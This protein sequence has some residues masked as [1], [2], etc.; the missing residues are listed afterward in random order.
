MCYTDTT[1]FPFLQ[2]YNSALAQE[3]QYCTAVH[4]TV[5]NLNYGL[6]WHRTA[7]LQKFFQETFL[8]TGDQREN[9]SVVVL[10]LL[11]LLLLL[12]LP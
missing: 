5:A 3:T 7:P 12:V 2:H 4:Y 11:L 1:I 8:L 9:V 6:H 10:L